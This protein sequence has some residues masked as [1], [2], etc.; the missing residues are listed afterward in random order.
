VVAEAVNTWVTMQ[1]ARS[2]PLGVNDRLTLSGDRA[3]VHRPGGIDEIVRCVPR[4]AEV[5]P[6]PAS[7]TYRVDG[8][9]ID[10][11]HSPLWGTVIMKDGSVIEYGSFK[12]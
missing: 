1:F 6:A 11:S 9:V 10:G 12:P 2:I 8:R 4:T 7:F 5:E 3:Y